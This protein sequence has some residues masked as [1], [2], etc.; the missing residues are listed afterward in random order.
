MA[1]MT[2]QQAVEMALQYQ[3]AGQ[4][5]E[6]QALCRQM[7]LV[8]PN[9]LQIL[10][11]LAQ[12]TF[13]TG[14]PGEAEQLLR[15]AVA[16]APNDANSLSN[17]GSVLIAE[18]KFDQAIEAIR[19]AMV[20]APDSPEIH[21]N[22]ANALG[23]KGMIDEAI[24]EYQRALELNPNL[25]Q[26]HNN[27]GSSFR[28][29][30]DLESAV[31]HFRQ[32]LS[33]R[34]DSAETQMNLGHALKE[35]KRWDEAAAA[36]EQAVRL[37]PQ[38]P[39]A[40]LNLANALLEWGRLQ[41]AIA[42]YRQALALHADLAEAHY[43]LGCALQKICDLD[44]AI[45]AFQRA[46]Q[47]KSDYGD[48]Y[49]N[50]G[51]VHE[52]KGEFDAAVTALSRAIAINPD[53]VLSHNNLGIVYHATGR[54]ADAIN[55]Y[56][57]TLEIRPGYPEALAN[58]ALVLSEVGQL[59]EAIDYFNK[60]LEQSPD[61]PLA[62]NNLA[63]ALKEMGRIDEALDVYRRAIHTM[64]EPWAYDNLLFGLYTHPGYGPEE[65]F[66]EHM[67]WAQK[68]AG[69][70]KPKNPVFE[71][72]RTPERKL[73]I[74][75]VSPDFN[76][77]PVGRFLLPLLSN[78]D[79]AKFEIFCYSDVRL[80]DAVTE[81]LKVH[82]DVWRRTNG[83]TDERLAQMIR[84][85]RID[86]LVDLTS[87]TKDN[88]LLVFAR[89]PAPVQATYLAYCGTTGLD[90]IDY[91]LTDP[92]LDPSNSDDRFYSEHSYR[93]PS[94][95]WCY[96]A[97]LMSPPVAPLPAR[98]NGSITF[99]CLNSFTKVSS[100]SLEMWC[101]LLQRVPAS[102]LLLHAREGSHR[103][104]V[105]DLLTENQVDPQRLEFVPRLAVDQYFN[106]YA[107]I[108]I[109]LDPYPYPGGTTTCDAL[110]MGVPVVSLVGKTA[111]SRGGHSILSNVGLP[112]LVAQSPEQ[113]VEIAAG[114]AGNVDR[115]ANLRAGLRD[116][117]RSSPLLDA[118]KFARDVEAAFRDMW[119]QW[120]GRGK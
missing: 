86:I 61:Q 84:Q 63:N 115:L 105:S 72:D 110:W 89:K 119:R 64:N 82:S 41:E 111:V 18:R 102:R 8:Q 11:L 37:R 80:P 70:L 112:E 77:H 94:T 101:K 4:L 67:G 28:T 65:I 58:L 104:R 96:L 78:H 44:D 60:A 22:L 1:Q 100:I 29:K 52:E 27:L 79:R 2:L 39:Q 114:L 26:V 76:E 5:G 6:A 69:P 12:L 31:G 97:P 13:Q 14:Q 46:V 23:A 45:D 73:R 9:D 15:R 24:S 81:Q 30:G 36:Y 3:R 25:P 42:S 10:Q 66:K 87:H 74:G 120:R 75:Y 62:L 50:L 93:L 17:L 51:M 16:L 118:S 92:Y 88:R 116:R 49:N 32:S 48:A 55:E 47:I 71:N 54:S 40:H 95:Y 53:D 109:A 35:V 33:L 108:D 103:Q 83:L 21:G 99:G 85:D 43:R 19:R 20:L 68:F 57:R 90:T 106:Q 7:L 59:E 98:E 34:P 56:R 113:Y 38:G 91:R 107:K 117:M